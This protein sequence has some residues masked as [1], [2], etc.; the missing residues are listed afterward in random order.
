MNPSRIAPAAGGQPGRHN[1]FDAEHYFQR[2]PATGTLQ[3]HGGQRAVT[4]PLALLRH[5]SA[6]L[7]QQL[8]PESVPVIYKCGFEWGLRDM[9]ACHADMLDAYGRGTL[10]PRSMNRRFVFVSWWFPLAAQGWGTA[11]LTHLDASGLAWIEL[12][13]AIDE[14]PP[15]DTLYAGLFAGALSFLESSARHSLEF[16]DATPGHAAFLIGAEPLIQ[17][18][19]ERRAQGTTADEIRSHFFTR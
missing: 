7:S 19:A 18:A 10:D 14:S 8:G 2:D 6:T 12:R 9:Q 11:R 4:A 16:R 17:A 13:H 5:L 1:R 3:L 15:A